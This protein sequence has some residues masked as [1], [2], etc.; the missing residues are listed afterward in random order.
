MSAQTPPFFDGPPIENPQ[1][2]VGRRAELN[3]LATRMTANPPTSINVVGDERIGKSSLLRHFVRTYEQRLSQFGRKADEFL[4]V[5]LSLQAAHCQREA[6]FFRTVAECL[7][8]QLTLTRPMLK[9]QFRQ[10]EWTRITFAQTCK[11]CAENQVLPV[12]CLD[13]FKELLAY[14]GTDNFD[15]GFLQQFTQSDPS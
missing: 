1:Y 3:Q 8:Q 10:S 6:D 15:A 7:D 4:V 12:V 13:G 5:Y 9:L 11:R 2:F 14:K